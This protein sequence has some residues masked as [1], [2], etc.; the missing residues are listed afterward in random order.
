MGILK[1]IWNTIF[2][3]PKKEKKYDVGG[4]IE[5]HKQCGC[6]FD[7]VPVIVQKKVES[8]SNY[9]ENELGEPNPQVC[10]E[11]QESVNSIDS[12]IKSEASEPKKEDFKKA[13]N[14][15]VRGFKNLTKE[16]EVLKYLLT[17]G[18]IDKF[19]CK[20]KFGLK[21]LDNTICKWR[22]QGMPIVN[23][24]IYVNNYKG[25]KFKVTNYRLVTENGAN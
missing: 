4:K 24:I 23:E 18:S 7:F 6:S 1:D 16:K 10:K 2:G 11:V 13:Y 17:Y 22:K 20:E 25:E 15:K 8:G 9:A 14:T 3:K 21:R 19:F 5:D 12:Q